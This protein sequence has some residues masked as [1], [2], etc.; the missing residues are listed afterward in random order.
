[1]NIV[2]KGTCSLL[3]S[4][5]TTR[6]YVHSSI[7][8]PYACKPCHSSRTL[9]MRLWYLCHRC[10]F[11][12]TCI[13]Y[14]HIYG[15]PGVH[16]TYL[17][18]SPPWTRCNNRECIACGI[19]DVVLIFTGSYNKKLEYLLCCRNYTPPP[20]LLC[21][22]CYHYQYNYTTTATPTT[23]LLLHYYYYNCC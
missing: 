13:V 12:I 22:C 18:L 19:R 7:F 14:I 5:R 20:S 3:F 17:W 6:R 4:I 10:I 1:M 21:C 8:L 16:S 9:C 23:L 11:I 2:N 15:C